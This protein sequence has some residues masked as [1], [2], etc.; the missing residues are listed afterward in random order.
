MYIYIYIYTYPYIDRIDEWDVMRQHCSEIGVDLE[1]GM[2]NQLLER[3]VR[4]SPFSKRAFG[5]HVLHSP[6]V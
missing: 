4:S 5:A 2:I 3:S 6:L 1:I